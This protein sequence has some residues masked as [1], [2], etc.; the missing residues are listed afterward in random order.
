[1]KIIYSNLIRQLLP[2]HKRQTLRLSLLQGFSKPLQLLFSDFDSWK[3]NT[4]MMLNVNSQIKILEGYLRKKY[5]EPFAISILSYDD[6]LFPVGNQEEGETLWPALPMDVSE[7]DAKYKIADIPLEGEIKE[8]FGDV[9]FT[10]YIPAG[11]DINIIRSEIEKYKQA[12]IQYK[13]IQK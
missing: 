4:Y 9:D 10:V 7:E 13:I 5:N 11:L 3:E 2:P 12:L 1:M 8:Q 6:G